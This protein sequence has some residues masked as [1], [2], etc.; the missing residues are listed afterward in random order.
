[1]NI[2]PY[3]ERDALINA[4]RDNI[5]QVLEINVNSHAGSKR[6]TL[7]VAKNVQVHVDRVYSN[8]HLGRFA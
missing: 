3:Q 5:Y 8:H 7:K 1:M 4:V 2:S 6:C